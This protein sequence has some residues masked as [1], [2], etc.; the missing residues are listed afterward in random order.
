MGRL[1]SHDAAGL[2]P[3]VP[4]S[5]FTPDQAPYMSAGEQVANGV[6]PRAD[7]ADGPLRSP[8]VLSDA[9][10][11]ACRG[12][13]AARDKNAASYVIA[14]TTTKL[15]QQNVRAWDDKSTGTYAVPTDG[16]WAFTQFG[17]LILATNYADA[18]QSLT[19]GS[20]VFG[21]LSVDA[22][23]AKFIATIEPGFVMV[24]FYSKA[25]VMAD[26]VWWSALNDATSWPTPGTLAA[27]SVQSD[28]QQL[29]GGGS[30]TGI[31]P[32]IGG[33]QGVIFTERALYRVEYVG[34]P[35]TFAFR[36]IDRS[37]GCIASQSLV[38]VGPV[39]YF[40]SEDGF[41]SFN[42]TAPQ[43]IGFGRVDRFFWTTVDQ[44]QL[45]SVYG[46]VDL[47]RKLIIWA[48]PTSGATTAK[49]WLIYNYAV[50][51]WR[52]GDDAALTVEYLYPARTSAYNLDNLDTV[53]PGGIDV[54]NF[55]V[56]S[57]LYQGG[58]RV[59]A[60]FDASH[61]LVSFDGATLAARV[62]T[63]DVNDAGK[64]VFV[65][66]IRVLTD[67]VAPMVGLRYR[68]ALSDAV[69]YSA[70]TPVGIDQMCPQRLDTRYVGAVLQINAGDEW[71]YLQGADVHAHATG[72]R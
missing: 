51:R 20:G 42:G 19:M 56:D 68:N 53:L 34:P 38:Q 24:G 17:Q 11:S 48:Y 21:A 33:A 13:F 50:D 9:L 22:P 7:G 18:I 54:G 45:E 23:L 61:R 63:G 29:P 72:W 35:V 8:T 60:G 15:Y 66:G 32:A 70:P 4:V 41:Y 10:L 1:L 27:S 43:S 2:M 3:V 36:E 64:R 6:Y 47:D 28:N 14:G 58:R 52:Y 55:N 40:L 39:A 44:T 49:K 59:L 26:G 62:E 31:L 46:T 67:A 12:A 57:S 37:R 25:G 65:G 69:Q 16:H 5:D 71:T 30:V